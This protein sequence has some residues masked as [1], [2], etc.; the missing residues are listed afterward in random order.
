MSDSVALGSRI[1]RMEYPISYQGEKERSTMSVNDKIKSLDE[2]S[3][4]IQS[5]KRE[6]NT[7]VQCHGVFDLL[8][9]G[10]ILHFEAAKREGDILVVTVTRDEH[11]DKGPGRPV[12]NQRI[13]TESIAALQCVDYV[14]LNEWP[15]AVETIKKLKPDIYVKGSEYAEADM[16]GR[17]YAEAEA[18][19]SIGGRV[20]FTDEPVFSSSQLLNAYFHIYPEEAEAFLKEF[21]RN[22]SAEDIIQRLEELKTMKVLVIGDT[23]IDE[24]HYCYA[25]GKSPKDSIIRTKYVSEE[26]FAGGVLASANHVAGFCENVHLVTC[27]GAENNPL[28]PFSKGDNREK[29]ILEHL[30]PNIKPKFF[31]REDAPTIV[32]RRFVEPDFLTKLF[33]ICFLNDR[34]L[35]EPAEQEVCNYLIKNIRD[36]DL[37]IVSDF[38]HGFIGQ[39]IINVLC[40]EANFLA[41]NTPTKPENMGFNL[42]T[43]YP[44]VN[45]VCINEPE[46]RLTTHDRFGKL[47][48]LIVIISEKL[49]CRKIAVTRGPKGSLTYATEEG[50]FDVPV[51][52]TEVVDRVGAGDAYFAITSPC[53]AA[54]N[55]MDVVGFIGNAVGAL[56]VRIV[57]NRSAVEPIPLFKFITA[58]LK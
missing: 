48:D 4:I 21:R 51:F 20:H 18:V 41:V 1:D 2:L 17:I 45:Y 52:S 40:E 9:P 14:A 39:S 56:A 50:F 15:T 6:G 7:V 33:E 47:E 30:K 13:R 58:L 44:K 36:Y 55:P 8:H 11:V 29:F 12:F 5:L 49:E 34:P 43:K 38:G 57:C 37:V 27:L 46:V 10:H 25:L 23:I 35:P 16:T 54:S 26:S 42:I 24:Y 22:Y 3:Y 53:V 28:A 31:Y 32:K 19:K